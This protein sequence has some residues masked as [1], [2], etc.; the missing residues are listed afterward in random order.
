VDKASYFLDLHV[1]IS[2]TVGDTAKDTIN[3]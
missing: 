2:K 1:N 3:H